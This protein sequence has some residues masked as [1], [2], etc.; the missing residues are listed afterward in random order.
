M[1]TS[2]RFFANIVI[3][4]FLLVSGLATLTHG[5]MTTQTCETCGM[6][7]AP[8][9]QMHLKAVDSTGTTHYVD[10]LRCALKLLN[11]Y[12]EIN[13]TT[14]C[15]WNGPTYAITINL[16]DYLN[17]TYVTPSTALFID[18]GCTKNRVVYNQAAADALIANN[19]TSPY[20]T[21]MQN[22]TIPSNAT[23]M[24]IDQAAIK[25]GFVSSPDPTTTPTPSPTPTVSSI[26]S[27]ANSLTTTPTAKPTASPTPI[28]T[29]N[30]TLSPTSISTQ[31]CEACGMEVS[32]DAQAKYV[33]TDGNGVTHYAE[34]YMCA[35]NLI[36]KYDQLTITSYC[37]WYGPNSAVTVES[38]QFGKVV[39][40]TPSTAMFLNGG[41][42]VIN[43][44]AYNQT[45]ADA[46]L[47][48][49]FS[50]YTLPMQHYDLPATTKVTTVEN[51]ALTYAGASHPLTSQTPLLLIV[52]AVM[53]VV[54][55]SIAALAFWKMKH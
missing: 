47:A 24:T 39:N 4:T 12:N 48:N 55:V 38:S 49:G 2:N 10:C 41:S 42:C 53:G 45:A 8:D 33:I 9:A 50:M 15:D 5:Q 7:V 34:C 21:M 18:G 3:I 37:D 51:A 29:S 44:V 54:I 14:N 31:A 16:T 20:L 32:A 27:P 23:I 6:M 17:K 1:R 11:T 13:I 22:V 35:L 52:A 26:S 28:K 19:G 46:L 40:V 25:Y 30:P 36:N 43:R